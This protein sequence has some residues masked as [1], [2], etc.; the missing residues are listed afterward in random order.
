[1]SFTAGN[2]AGSDSATKLD[3]IT[4]TQPVGT[5]MHVSN[6]T[7][8]RSSQ[9]PWRRGSADVTVVDQNGAAVAGA[10]VTGFFSDPTTASVSAIT[11]SNGTASFTSDKTRTPPANWCFDVTGVALAGATYNSGANVWT[12]RCEDGSGFASSKPVGTAS[13]GV[14]IAGSGL[15]RSVPNPLTRSATISFRVGAAGHVTLEVFDVAGR[16]VAM[17]ADRDYGPGTYNMVWDAAGAH[18]GI[19]FYRLAVGRTVETR[20]MIV[21]R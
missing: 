21:V 13:L 19:Y 11:G 8:G 15:S 7:V 6:I 10:T 4:V 12:H 1:M 14:G 5:V 9:G 17:L 16:R 18:S 2:G 20:K 3:Y